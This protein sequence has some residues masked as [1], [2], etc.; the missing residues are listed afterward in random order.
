[1]ISAGSFFIDFWVHLL[2]LVFMGFL[3][4]ILP[5]NGQPQLRLRSE[6]VGKYSDLIVI[7]HI[8]YH[9]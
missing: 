2:I 5:T 1:M 6:V 9:V 8:I 3:L 7:Y 4:D